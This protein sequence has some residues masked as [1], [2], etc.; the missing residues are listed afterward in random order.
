MN[1]LPFLLIGTLSVLCAEVYSGASQAWF[2]DAWGL[3]IVLPL[4]LSHLLFFLNIAFRIKKTSLLQLYFFGAIFALYESWVTKVLW[5][6]YPNATVQ[7]STFLGIAY[8]EFS[9]LV[10]YWH[11]V[12][13]FILPI[14]IF[15]IL[16]G[17]VLKTHLMQKSRNKTILLTVAA[18]SVA[19][20]NTNGS[21]YNIVLSNLAIIGSMI[22]VMFLSKILPK[23]A[24]IYSLKLNNKKFILLTLY[25]LLLYGVTFFVL[26]P[27]RIPTTPLP[28]IIILLIYTIF[29]AIL[30]KSK[31]VEEKLVETNEGYTKKDLLKF[32]ALTIVS[33][34]IFC[35]FP[36][37]AQAGILAIFLIMT[38]GA[39][40]LFIRNLVRISSKKN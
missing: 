3:L 6:G 26:L 2:I 18:I 24:T 35:I 39:P 29:I 9:T 31:P 34:N 7:A 14:L 28:I 20:F 27:E 22:L 13:A 25:I 33:A 17:K 15:E 36:A 5:Y 12:M 19:L 23:D 37:L 40:I 32:G 11:P 38:L 16:T 30:S 8:S 10:F 21:Q 1:L 4:Y